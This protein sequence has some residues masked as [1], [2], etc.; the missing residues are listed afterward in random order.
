[1][2]YMWRSFRFD[3]DGEKLI[4]DIVK[5]G[6]E[7]HTIVSDSTA[8]GILLKRRSWLQRLLRL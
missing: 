7:V 4:N 1:M 3:Q 6:W 2:K 8:I 5:D